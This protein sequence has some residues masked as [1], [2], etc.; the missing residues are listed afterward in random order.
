MVLIPCF[1]I[2]GIVYGID[3]NR[4][5]DNKTTDVKLDIKTNDNVVNDSNE[6]TGNTTDDNGSV[7]EVE[8]N[9]DD[10]YGI[11]ENI[12]KKDYRYKEVL[13]NKDIYPEK[14]L[15]MLSRNKDMISYM[16]DFGDKKGHVYI[17]NIGKV[18]KGEYP[19][20]L[21]YD[22]KWGYG[23]YGDNVIAVNG[24]G[25]TSLAMVVAG[26]TGKNDTTPYDIA[27]YSYEKGYYTEEWGTK[28]DL[29]STGVEPFGVTGK[30]IVLSKQNLYNELNS[31]HPLIA[32]MRPGDFT[33]VG[34]FI[35]LTGIKDDKIVVN[36]PNSKERS[37]KLWE[38]DVIAPQIKGL[39]TYSLIN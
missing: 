37:T 6:V 11:L 33:T 13:A 29:M 36:D 17:D 34:H 22:K 8:V 21:Q 31:G 1:A 7:D 14:L 26:L 32:S 39:W 10:I 27:K 35:V 23:I 20:L 3:S 15:E 16:Y 28:W 19:L 18:T 25:P 9:P 12:A 2:V 4:V 24:C 30:K 5:N 38:Y